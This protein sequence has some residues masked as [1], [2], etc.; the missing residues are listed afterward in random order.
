[1]TS[2]TIKSYTDLAY[3][4]TLTLDEDYKL[5]PLGSVTGVNY[6][7]QLTGRYKKGIKAPYYLHVIGTKGYSEDVPV[8]L[9]NAIIRYMKKEL[10][11]AL[12]DPNFEGKRIVESD[13]G[14]SGIKYYMTQS[15]IN[16]HTDS[17]FSDSA[18]MST[19]SIFLAPP[20]VH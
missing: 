10:G 5:F 12:Q 8:M 20:E 6:G 9:K 3:S 16:E 19:L 17:A 1:M 14:K 7:I 4:Q 2:I 13:T 11:L 18:F 15:T